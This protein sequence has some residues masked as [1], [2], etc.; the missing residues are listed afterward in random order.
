MQLVFIEL[1]FLQGPVPRMPRP[2]RLKPRAA[3][4]ILQGQGAEEVV[5]ILGDEL[6]SFAS[7]SQ[8]RKPTSAASHNADLSWLA[9]VI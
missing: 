8:P 2:R 1:G 4:L 9:A 6:T 7:L 5:W 3:C